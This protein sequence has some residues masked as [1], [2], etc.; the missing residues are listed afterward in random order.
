MNV[1]LLHATPIIIG[2][3]AVRKCYKSF[4]HSDNGGEKDRALLHKVGNKF[5][6]ESVKNHINFTFDINNIST[7]TLL[8]LTRHD[9]GVEFSV[10]STR[11][12]LAKRHKA[13]EQF[14]YSRTN[15]I[16]VNMHLDSIMDMVRECLDVG[17]HNDDVAMLLPQAYHYSLVCTFSLT[18]LQHFLELRL[19][20]DAHFDIRTLAKLLGRAIPEEYK[21]LF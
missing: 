1:E 21:Y 13:G 2:S 5:K 10:E 4:G 20:E 16:L 15:S 6:H 11:F 18:A 7:K 12:T 8:A 9:V 17:V 14:T 3:T 19:A